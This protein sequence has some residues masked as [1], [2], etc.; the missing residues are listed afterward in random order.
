MVAE[1]KSSIRKKGAA[2]LKA[3]LGDGD[4]VDPFDGQ[5]C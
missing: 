4:L 5:C 3:A 2:E 1:G